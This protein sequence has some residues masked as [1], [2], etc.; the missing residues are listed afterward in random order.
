MP[1]MHWNLHHVKQCKEETGQAMLY[2]EHALVSYGHDFGQLTQVNPVAACIPQSIEKLQSFLEYANQHHLPV[3]VRGKGLS[4]GGQSLPVNGGV[5]LHLEKLNKVHEHEVDS[6]WI[7]S[8]ASWAT[9]LAKSLTGYQIPYVIPYNC[10]LSIGGILSA[11]GVGASSFKYGSIT[12]HVEAL[13]VV[14]ADGQLK[15]IDSKSELFQACLSGQGRFAVITKACIKL[16]H[17]LKNVR[18][19]FLV[20]L[21]KEQWLHDIQEVRGRADYIE[22][23]CSPSI[24]GAKLTSGKRLPF[25]QWLYA[26]HV[27][28][29][30]DKIPPE[31]NIISTLDPWKI[32]HIQDE[33][34]HSYLHRHDSRFEAMKLTGQWDLPHPWYECFIPTRVLADNLEMLLLELPLHYATVLQIVPM[35]NRPRTGFFMFPDS[36]DFCAVMILNPGVNPVLL[37]GCLQAI[38]ELD[39][40]FLSTGGKRYLSGYLGERV[41]E[42]YWQK[43]FG[44]S[45]NDWSRLKKKYDSHHIL[46]SCLHHD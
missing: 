42:K 11:G 26:L 5:T 9:L 21:K 40:L 45:Y 10:N 33:S 16:R 8:N 28:I 31:V 14:Q 22:S 7:E 25:A 19:F 15:V 23:F 37:P 20:Y 17:C 43:H 12:S 27:S 3:T 24:Q 6:I 4:Q 34:I 1:Q 18:T 30:Y 41:T 44:S 36:N 13:E 29:E 46:K 32:I 38:E 39:R 35:A 2:D